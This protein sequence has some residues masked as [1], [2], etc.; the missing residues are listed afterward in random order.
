MLEW[1]KIKLQSGKVYL[2]NKGSISVVLDPKSVVRYPKSEEKQKISSM[3]N[4]LFHTL[5]V[6]IFAC[7]YFGEL[8]KIALCEYLCEYILIFAN[9]KFLKILSLQIS[10]PKKQE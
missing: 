7:I 6:L 3:P 1:E 8:R 9:G 2:I 5:S 10:A 4:Q